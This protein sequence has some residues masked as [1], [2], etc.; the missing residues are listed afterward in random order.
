MN[1]KTL[2]RVSVILLVFAGLI[3]VFQDKLIFFPA[4]WPEGFKLPEKIGITTISSVKIPVSDEVT[5]DAIFASPGLEVS[6]RP[7]TILYNHGNAGNLLHRLERVNKLCEMGF[8]V[9]VYDYRG[10]GRSSGAPDVEGAI[11]DGKAA[12]AFLQKTF[13][14]KPSEIIIY[15]ESLGTGVATE[16]VRQNPASYSAL[17]LESGF[18]SLSAQANRRFPLIGGLILKR[19]LPTIDFLKNYQ[20]KLLIIHSKND[21]IIPYSDSE[22]LFAASSSKYKQMLTLEGVGHNAPVWNKP[23][24]RPAWKALFND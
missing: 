17:V 20:G 13:N 8:S 3:F 18:A 22:K 1:K 21:E 7:Q 19:D 14:F 6:K 15:G 12:L 16:L 11:A 5:L 24:Y 10:F 9:L 23:E 4:A 2:I